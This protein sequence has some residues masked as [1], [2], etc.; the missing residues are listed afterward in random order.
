M[1]TDDP[2]K[3]AVLGSG[4]FCRDPRAALSFL[5][6]AFGFEPSMLVSDP[7]GR[8]VQLRRRLYHRRFR[9]G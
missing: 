5:Q 6:A 1:P 2:F 9:M 8:L 3:H 4:V 7:D